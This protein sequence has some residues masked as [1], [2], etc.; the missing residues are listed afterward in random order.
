MHSW[1]L[2]KQVCD[3]PIAGAGAYASSGLGD[4]AAAGDC[5][6]M[7]QVGI[8]AMSSAILYTCTNISVDSPLHSQC[9]FLSYV[10][11]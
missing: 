5:D 10:A 8:S 11:T 3:S 4:A 6:I 9:N 2:F 1:P 7:T